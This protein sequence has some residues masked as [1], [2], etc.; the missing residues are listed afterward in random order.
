LG[1]RRF[2]RAGRKEAIVEIM[3]ARHE[4][5]HALMEKIGASPEDHKR[6]AEILRKAA[7]EIRGEKA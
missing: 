7:A 6:I 2:G 5:K 4:L 3:R 1:E